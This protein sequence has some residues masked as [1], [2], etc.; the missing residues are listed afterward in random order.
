M[1]LRSFEL[2]VRVFGGS[3][4]TFRRRTNGVLCRKCE[5]CG[6]SWNGVGGGGKTGN[7]QSTY[8]RLKCSEMQG[9]WQVNSNSAQQW[10][11]RLS[12]TG[13]ERFAHYE[14]GS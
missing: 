13:T 9:V 3:E 4:I 14:T 1:F 8:L 5:G 10:S 6:V 7:E 11:H 2:T 12:W